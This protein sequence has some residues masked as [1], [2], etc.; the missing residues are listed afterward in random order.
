MRKH[1]ARPGAHDWLFDGNAVAHGVLGHHAR[2]HELEQVV[3]TAGLREKRPPV[4]AK[5]R[6]STTSMASSTSRTLVTDR[7]GPKISSRF[8]GESS[9]SPTTSDGGANQ[10]S[11]GTGSALAARRSAACSR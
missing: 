9:G 1:P 7:S 3:R 8:T 11:S 10:P 4:R 6:E 2:L 5:G